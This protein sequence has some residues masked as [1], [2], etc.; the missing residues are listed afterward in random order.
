M[1]VR[2][3]FGEP[4]EVT[5]L[6]RPERAALLDV[7][8][9]LTDEEWV[10]STA[11]PGWSVH[12]I[13]LHLLGDD[14]RRLSAGRD[15]HAASHLGPVTSLDELVPLLDE[16]NESWVRGARM[17]SPK[18]TIE[19]LEWSADPTERHLTELPPEQTGWSVSWVAPDPAPNWMDVAREYTE[20]WVHQQQIRDAVGKPGLTERRFLAPVID[21]F[22]RALPRALPTEGY[23]DGTV[24]HVHVRD[25]L[26]RTWA[27]RVA[28]GQWRLSEPSE[29]P[30]ASVLIDPDALWRRAVRMMDLEQVTTRARLDGDRQ[31]AA[32]VLEIRSAIVA[33]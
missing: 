21:A 25:P 5:A 23:A 22:L 18:L 10:R 12:D 33:V 6:F 16:Q 7:L 30:D 27:A 31:L 13:S 3:A 29:R 4:I 17:L 2:D 32:A 8:R 26:D 1:Q 15:R 24:V 9:T 19:L 28:D 11:C 14:L 20:R